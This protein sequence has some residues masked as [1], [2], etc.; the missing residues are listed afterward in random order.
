VIEK[1]FKEETRTH[2]AHITLGQWMVRGLVRQLAF[3]ARIPGPNKMEKWGWHVRWFI[4]LFH[5]HFRFLLPFPFPDPLPSKTNY[6]LTSISV[7]SYSVIYDGYDLIR[8]DGGM[9]IIISSESMR[10]LS[11]EWRGVVW[12]VFLLVLRLPTCVGI[13]IY[14]CVCQHMCI[15]AEFERR[16]GW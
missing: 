13:Y 3:G 16:T 7:L 6:L 1:T 5:F 9:G 8:C 15:C 2:R 14:M 12:R 11:G 4:K 10:C